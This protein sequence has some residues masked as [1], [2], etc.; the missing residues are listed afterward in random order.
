MEKPNEALEELEFFAALFLSSLFTGAT[1]VFSS[2]FINNLEI[3]FIGNV[4]I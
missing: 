2:V 1:G 3:I 4:D